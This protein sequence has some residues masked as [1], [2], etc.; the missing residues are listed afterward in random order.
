M[1]PYTSQVVLSALKLGL[2]QQQLDFLREQY[3]IRA[4]ALVSALKKYFPLDRQAAGKADG[5]NQAFENEGKGIYFEEPEG[6]FF[7]WLRLPRTSNG[8]FIDAK[9]LKD[10]YGNVYKEGQLFRVEPAEASQA[11]QPS[12]ANYVRLSF[13]YYNVED[14]EKGVRDLK[15]FMDHY[16]NRSSL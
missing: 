4:S 14:L 5:I 12:L 10:L 9:K 7:I 13:A 2:A 6:G 16:E 1:N 8:Q 11:E 15:A 3:A